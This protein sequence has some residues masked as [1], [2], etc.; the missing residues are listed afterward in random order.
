MAELSIGQHCSWSECKQLDFLPV[1]C[2]ACGLVFCKEHSYCDN[3][4]CSRNLVESSKPVFSGEKSYRCELTGCKNTELMEII[5]LMCEKNFCLAHRHPPDHL[6]K[7]L[8]APAEK[9]TKTSQHI[10]ELLKTSTASTAPKKKKLTKKARET[11]AKVNLMKLKMKAT[12]N[13]SIPELE[14]VFFNIYLPLNSK[15][16]TKAVFVSRLWSVGRVID[17]VAAESNLRNDNNVVG[18][19]K[20]KLFDV[21]GVLLMTDKTVEYYMCDENLLYNGSDV[22]LEYVDEDVCQLDDTIGYK[23]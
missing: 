10:A 9:T 11:A 5:C 19:K 22:I 12:G 20:L 7:N 23:R 13:K 17:F 14:R 15:M 4:N 16:K 18:A 21:E 3:H 2:T 8:E 1:K 6:C